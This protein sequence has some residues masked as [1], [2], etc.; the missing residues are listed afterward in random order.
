MSRL[1]SHH[2]PCDNNRQVQAPSKRIFVQETI[3]NHAPQACGAISSLLA[4]NQ[5]IDHCCMRRSRLCS[6]CPG[7]K[8]CSD[9]GTHGTGLHL[10]SMTRQIIEN[11]LDRP[12][13]HALLQVHVRTR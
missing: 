13:A 11:S 12:A 5:A 1:I 3:V 6:W 9:D 8:H 10:H 4:L 2:L 7:S